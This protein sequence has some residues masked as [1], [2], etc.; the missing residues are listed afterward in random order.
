MKKKILFH[1][2]LASQLLGPLSLLPSIVAYFTRRVNCTLIVH[3]SYVAATL[4]LGLLITGIL[5]TK[6]YKCLENPRILIVVLVL[7]QMGATALVILDVIMTRG[8]RRLTGSCVQVGPMTFT[9]I[10][11]IVQFAQSLLICLCF[12][13]ACYKSRGSPASR[14]RMSVRVSLDDIPIQMPPAD[15]DTNPQSRGWWDHIPANEQNN[16]GARAGNPGNS[17]GAE[18][19]SPSGLTAVPRREQ[20]RR[21]N[22]LDSQANKEH[23]ATQFDSSLDASPIDGAPGSP[24][25]SAGSRLSRLLPKMTLFGK[26]VKDELLY[27]TLITFTCVIVA[28]FALVGLHFRTPLTVTGWIALNWAIISL[29]TVHS[30]GRVVHRHER[31][32]WIQQ[33]ASRSVRFVMAQS[34]RNNSRRTLAPSTRTPSTFTSRSKSIIKPYVRAG[35]RNDPYGDAQP[36]DA[37]KMSWNFG[38]IEPSPPRP[39]RSPLLFSVRNVTATNSTVTQEFEFETAERETPR[40][41]QRNVSWKSVS[42][43]RI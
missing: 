10:F 17:P 3:F 23:D 40:Q 19:K 37:E 24:A 30:F 22:T 38:S 41:L 16:A 20:R 36:L 33:S 27:T 26:V 29:L 14:G 31:E 6:A 43:N 39:A 21:A 4:S 28:V 11:V 2:L 8:S 35:D 32:S 25:W 18:L 5:G 7:L 34:Q 13:Y 15:E 9:R 42:A 12:V 1:V